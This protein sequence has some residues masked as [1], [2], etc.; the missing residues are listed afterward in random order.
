M[1]STISV[2]ANESLPLQLHVDR[3]KGPKLLGS[4]ISNGK[5]NHHKK[6]H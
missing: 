2:T 5:E 1:N 4:S 3:E 6:S